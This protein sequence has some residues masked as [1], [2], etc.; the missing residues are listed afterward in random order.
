MAARIAIWPLSFLQDCIRELLEELQ[1]WGVW[2]LVTSRSTLSTGLQGAE[3]LHLQPLAQE[4]AEALLKHRAG[5]DLGA[6]HV[7]DLVE[8]CQSN[9]L[10]LHV[11][12]GL[13]RSG[14]VRPEVRVVVE[15]FFLVLIF[16]KN[17]FLMDVMSCVEGVEVVS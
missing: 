10:Y 7:R 1:R 3:Q 9:S 6:D 15:V 13:L 12:G 2:L 17:H 8:L 5:D 14:A 4:S 16:V 11:I